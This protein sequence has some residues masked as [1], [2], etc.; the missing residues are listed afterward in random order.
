MGL[1]FAS[2]NVFGEGEI[3]SDEKAK[4]KQSQVSKT[5]IFDILRSVTKVKVSCTGVF[6]TK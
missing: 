3:K 6:E 2:G 4:G 5:V 1:G